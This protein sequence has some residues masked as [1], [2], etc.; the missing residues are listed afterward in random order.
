MEAEIRRALPHEGRS[1]LLKPTI[2][3]QGGHLQ[4]KAWASKSGFPPSWGLPEPGG[5]TW[6]S[7]A[8][9]KDCGDVSVSMLLHVQ[10]RAKISAM[11]AR[12]FQDFPQVIQDYLEEWGKKDRELEKKVNRLTFQGKESVRWVST[13][14]DKVAD[15][16]LA[17]LRDVKKGGRNRQGE[18]GLAIY[19]RIG[20]CVY[21]GSKGSR[22]EGSQAQKRA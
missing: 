15:L 16:K 21:L 6:G 11:G 10:S 3:P 7:A 5:N 13:A 14:E 20:Q 12:Q 17:G 8:H 19:R 22:R 2:L 18:G 1:R 9:L 4:V